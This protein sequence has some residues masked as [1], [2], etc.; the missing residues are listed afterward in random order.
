MNS[1]ITMLKINRYLIDKI[2][3]RSL[4]NIYYSYIS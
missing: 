1:K 4:K 2:I 3:K